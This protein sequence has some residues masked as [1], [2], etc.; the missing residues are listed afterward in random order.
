MSSNV[1]PIADCFLR[2][3]NIQI[4]RAEWQLQVFACVLVT[5]FET[6]LKQKSNGGRLD[7]VLNIRP[8][9]QILN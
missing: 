4:Q 9:A 7:I 3:Q 2:H 6:L 5:L 8:T 1:L